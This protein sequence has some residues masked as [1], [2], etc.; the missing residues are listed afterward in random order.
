MALVLRGRQ[1]LA[2]LTAELE[3]GCIRLL[4]GSDGRAAELVAV[5]AGGM[6][7]QQAPAKAAVVS[8]TWQHGSDFF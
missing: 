1:A 8:E 7:K 3:L 6:A 5:A 4:L 2:T